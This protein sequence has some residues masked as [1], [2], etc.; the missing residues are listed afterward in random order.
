M[1]HRSL[2]RNVRRLDILDE[3]A[4]STELLIPSHILANDMDMES[5][6][7]ELGMH[8]KQECF[9]IEVDIIDNLAF[10]SGDIADSESSSAKSRRAVVVS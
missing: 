8:E 4:A 1:V 2:A 3:R 9:L 10:S 5:T 7:D 6:D